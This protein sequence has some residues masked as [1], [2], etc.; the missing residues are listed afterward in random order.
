M[1]KKRFQRDTPMLLI[2]ICTCI[3][4]YT[5][6]NELS[7]M[8]IYIYSKRMCYEPEVLLHV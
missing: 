1:R 8:Y 2:V 4:T 3:G 6:N 7:S 5:Q